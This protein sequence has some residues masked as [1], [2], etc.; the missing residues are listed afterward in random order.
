VTAASAPEGTPGA[1]RPSLERTSGAFG[2]SPPA[3]PP[4]PASRLRELMRAPLRDPSPI[5]LKELRATF[6]TPGFIRFLYLTTALVGLAVVGG[7]ATLASGNQAPA[8]AGRTVFQLF[9][10]MLLAVI[11]LVAPGFAATAITSERE[12]H[13]YESLLL[14]G[15][16]GTRIVL[17]KLAA[18]VASIGLVVTAVAPIVGVAFLFG[19]SSPLAVLTG[20]FWILMVLVVTVAFG[21]AIS[22]HVQTT[23]VAI[24]VSTFIAIPVAM[25]LVSALTAVGEGAQS[26]WGIEVD[27]PFWFAHA[28]AERFDRAD[29]W[30]F[31]GFLPI[32]TFGMPTW[33]FVASAVAGVV[34]PSDDRST[35]LKIWAVA[36]AVGGAVAASLGPFFLTSPSD[37]GE[38]AVVFSMMGMTLVYFFALVLC[39]EPPL[40]PVERG[41]PGPLTRTFA[42]VGPGASGTLRFTLLLIVGT[43]FAIPGSACLAHH[44]AYPHMPIGSSYDQALLAIAIG[45]SAV[46]ACFAGLATTL[47]LALR[48]GGAARALSIAIYGGAIFAALILA[49]ALDLDALDHL[50]R[51]VSPIFAL[52]P[53]GP[54]FCAGIISDRSGSIQMDHWMLL[55]VSSIGYGFLAAAFWIGVEVRVASAKRAVAERRGR[56]EAKLAAM[57]RPASVPDA[58]IAEPTSVAEPTSGPLS[59]VEPRIEPKTETPPASTASDTARDDEPP[60]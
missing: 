5:L 44:V 28:F 40:P 4:R 36:A 31:L 60:A 58:P 35:A 2:S 23:R 17:G 54:A 47:R 21:I 57:T 53:M 18:Y 33:F 39:N 19:G 56:L 38:S 37:S 46:G 14:S 24:V 15:M 3:K 32:Y 25:I 51:D 27:G 45:Q 41:K 6:R 13:T 20:F 16:T 55:I 52:S 26:A 8:Q 59:E 29:T 50:D 9:F 7:G 34:P 22:A 10:S 49:A 48:N 30:A 11:C 42:V 12:A 1:D 43:A